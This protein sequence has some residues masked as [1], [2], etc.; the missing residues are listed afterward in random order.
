MS[1]E[2][3]HTLSDSLFGSNQCTTTSAG[4]NTKS[5]L[6]RMP[7]KH[8]YKSVVNQRS[9]GIAKAAALPILDVYS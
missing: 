1:P 4:V 7:D 3:P 6:F 2:K 9:I 8:T 5:I